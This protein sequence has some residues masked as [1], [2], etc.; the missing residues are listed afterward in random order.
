MLD[1]NPSYEE[2]LAENKR[3]KE[4]NLRLNKKITEM[5]WELN[6]DRMGGMFDHRIE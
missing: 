6:P 3:L 5:G 1:E 4:E 2:L